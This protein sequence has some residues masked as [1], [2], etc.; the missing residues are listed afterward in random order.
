MI[1]GLCVSPLPADIEDF[2]NPAYLTV[3]IT[4]RGVIEFSFHAPYELESD[5]P[6]IEAL[7]ATFGCAPSDM[8]VARG[9]DAEEPGLRVSGSCQGP[10]TREDLLVRADLELE[11]LSGRL[12]DAGVRSVRL[13][14]THAATAYHEAP[15]GFDSPSSD[16]YQAS[17]SLIARVSEWP[18]GLSW[19]F[20]YR[21]LDMWRIIGIAL[22]AF[23]VP[24]A[25]VYWLRSRLSQVSEQRLPS[26][27][28]LFRRYFAY[29]WPLAWWLWVPLSYFSGLDGFAAFCWTAAGVN[30]YGKIAYYSVWFFSICAPPLLASVACMAVAH[31]LL[32]RM[33]HGRWTAG[34]W[35]RGGLGYAAYAVPAMC[36]L[37]RFDSVLTLMQ[38]DWNGVWPLIGAHGSYYG[39]SWLAFWAKNWKP[40]EVT[41]GPFYERARDLADMETFPLERAY[42]V[43][44]GQP[45]S[46]TAMPVFRGNLYVSEYL[47]QTL[48]RREVDAVVR[49]EFRYQARFEEWSETSVG[50]GFQSIGFAA[51]IGFSFVADGT[52]LAGYITPVVSIAMVGI[53]YGRYLEH[54]SRK[55]YAARGGLF[56]PEEDGPFIKGSAK[57]APLSLSPLHWPSIGGE[58]LSTASRKRL[59]QIAQRRGISKEKVEAMLSESGSRDFYDLTPRPV[60][61][62]M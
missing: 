46:S 4:P 14:L 29:S 5:T 6:L 10:V 47:L 50:L 27:S 23:A 40:F 20:G 30:D 35:L 48:S 22:L 55:A 24:V 21:P 42:V 45:F 58:G 15:P 56:P 38:G 19:V 9:K 3:D 62:A 17:H 43:P 39:L 49:D 25:W 18:S 2:K 7:G 28:F 60:P 59:D 53:V 1:A 8:D 16:R 51:A 13:T 54:R 12:Q 31:P 34:S 11:S 26:M 61:P 32:S 41:A 36:V 33:P 44:L 37:W 52:A 57:L